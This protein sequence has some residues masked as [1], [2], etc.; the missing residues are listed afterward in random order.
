[1]EE[2]AKCGIEVISGVE[3]SVSDGI[4]DIHILGYFVDFADEVFRRE[5]ERFR[6]ARFERVKK[7]IAKLKDLEVDIEL[8]SVLKIADNG[9]I[10]WDKIQKVVYELVITDLRMPQV[11]GLE[12]LE[13]IRSS[14]IN[15]RLILMTAYGS[16]SVKAKA[17]QL[18]VARYLP[19]PIDI[20]ELIDALRELEVDID[21]GEGKVKVYAE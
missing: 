11:D 13:K 1:M 7:I 2:A 6:V 21:G 14:G 18:N 12:L 20:D 17:Q 15:T 4:S 5:L 8:E 10:A 16:E 9:S 19:K 3:L